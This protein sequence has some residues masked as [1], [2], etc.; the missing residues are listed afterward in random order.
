MLSTLSP[1]QI[2]EVRTHLQNQ[3]RPRIELFRNVNVKK[4]PHP[5][6]PQSTKLRI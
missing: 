2:R 5:L 1:G 3:E 6:L 4:V